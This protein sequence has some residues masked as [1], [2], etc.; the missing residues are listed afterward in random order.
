[1]KS[2]YGKSLNQDVGT[3]GKI[4][5]LFVYEIIKNIYLIKYDDCKCHKFSI[6][7]YKFQI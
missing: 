4:R 3:F 1:M 5:V 7:I 6:V 2:W